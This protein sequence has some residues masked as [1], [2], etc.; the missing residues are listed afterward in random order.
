MSFS[1]LCGSDPQG[2]VM[3]GTSEKGGWHAR[4]DLTDIDTTTTTASDLTKSPPGARVHP[5]EALILAQAR[6]AI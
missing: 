1:G 6:S 5:M 2:K 3:G 4:L